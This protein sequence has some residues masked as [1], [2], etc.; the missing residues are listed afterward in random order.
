MLAF[1]ESVSLSIMW[2]FLGLFLAIQ[3]KKKDEWD[4][5]FWNPYSVKKKKKKTRMKMFSYMEFA[6][7]LT[8]KIS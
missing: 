5:G 4:K 3:K 1:V 7:F 8:M 6:Y 2:T